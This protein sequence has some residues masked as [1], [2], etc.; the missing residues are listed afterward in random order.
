MMQSTHALGSE[1][2]RVQRESIEIDDLLSQVLANA[3]DF[4]ALFPQ[5]SFLAAQLQMVARMIS[6]HAALGVTRQVFFVGTGGWDTHDAQ[7]TQLPGL[8]A[9]MSSALAGFQA[10]VES[11]GEQNNVTG[12]THSEF[13]R[14][15][16]SN[17]QGS[18][19]AWGGNHFILGGGTQGGQIYGE[20]PESLSLGNPLDIDTFRGRILPTISVDEYF[21]ELA[22][23]LGV[24]NSDLTAGLP[25]IDRFY[26]RNSSSPPFGFLLRDCGA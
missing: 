20:Y 17:G 10:A 19:H 23:W 16:S 3:P 13:G 8:F 6:V 26:V 15:L 25:N 2:A 9:S 4:S 12:F 5:P 1:F 14:T 21:A 24:Q 11:V 7:T 18:D 22:C